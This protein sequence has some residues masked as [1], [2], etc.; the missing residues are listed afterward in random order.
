M[1]FACK[2][3]YADLF[4]HFWKILWNVE[5]LIH[6]NGWL[7]HVIFFSLFCRSSF[8]L[9]NSFIRTVNVRKVRIGIQKVL[10][11]FLIHLSL[12]AHLIQYCVFQEE[13]NCTLQFMVW[14]SWKKLIIIRMA[15]WSVSWRT[16]EGGGCCIDHKGESD[17]VEGWRILYSRYLLSYASTNFAK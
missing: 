7:T 9:F 8:F 11:Y 4:D 14:K 2:W 1:V 5:I 6:F 16:L 3:R 15:L 13:G 12:H 10:W 17:S